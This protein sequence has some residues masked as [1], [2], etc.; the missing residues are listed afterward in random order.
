MAWL[1]GPL[2]APVAGPTPVILLVIPFATF[3]GLPL[4]T[5]GTGV[6]GAP[7]ALA[8]LGPVLDPPA[9]PVVAITPVAIMGGP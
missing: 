6:V 2:A 4:P 3:E 7:T 8:R 1:G 5:P 9:V